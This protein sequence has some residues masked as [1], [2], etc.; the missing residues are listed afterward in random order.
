MLKLKNKNSKN[1]LSTIIIAYLRVTYNQARYIPGME[2]KIPTYK[3]QV[4][5]RYGV[6]SVISLIYLSK[7]FAFLI[8]LLYTVNNLVLGG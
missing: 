6:C 2:N 8:K 7:R 5:Y 3:S 1:F 4:C